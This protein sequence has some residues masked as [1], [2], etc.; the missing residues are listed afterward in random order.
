MNS[1]GSLGDAESD[2][3][4]LCIDCADERRDCLWRRAYGGVE[5]GHGIDV[6][7]D[8]YLPMFWQG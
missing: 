5:F 4:E 6:R 3:G 8:S 2:D 1:Q 7:V